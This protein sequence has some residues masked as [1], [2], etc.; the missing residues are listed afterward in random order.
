MNE[1]KQRFAST[2]AAGCSLL[3][4]LVSLI[5]LAIGFLGLAMQAVLQNMDAF[6]RAL[7]GR[8][9]QALFLGEKRV[10]VFRILSWRLRN[11]FHGSTS[12]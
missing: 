6:K 1:L 2:H 9:G 12:C 11:A 7:A 3:E 10:L 4:V 8:L 5:I